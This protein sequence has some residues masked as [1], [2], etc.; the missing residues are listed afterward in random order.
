MTMYQAVIVDDEKFILDGL[1]KSIDWDGYDVEISLASTDPAEALEYIEAHPVQILITDVSMPGMSGLE[2]IRKARQIKPSI[3]AVVLSAYDNFEYTKQALRYGAEDYLLKPLDPDELS[4]CVSQIISHLKEREQLETLY[5]QSAMTFRSTFTEQW[6]T[7]ALGISTLTSKAKILGINLDAPDYMVCIFICPD[8]G[9]LMISM[10]FTLLMKHILGH[11]MAN[12]Y[13]ETPS[14]L[15]GVFSRTESE[16]H[17]IREMILSTQKDAEANGLKIFVSAGRLVSSFSQA[18]Q[19]FRDARE[20]SFLSGSRLPCFF[21][22]DLPEPY[23]SV[24]RLFPDA[25]PCTKAFRSPAVKQLFASSDPQLC[26]CDVLSAA[27]S[28]LS[29]KEENPIGRHPELAALLSSFPPE[30]P[31]ENYTFTER[32]L[33]ASESAGAVRQRTYPVVDAVIDSLK[34][35]SD[36]DISLKTIAAKLNVSP[37]YLGT[38][39][40]QQT[41]SLF[42]RLPR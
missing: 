13:F 18:T 30:H 14:R 31:E 35:F 25:V 42:Q 33:Q 4:D 19:S 1:R 7:G 39:F 17:S 5:G 10:F 28:R 3:N 16:T 36:K 9:E 41:G 40:H 24:R 11:Y 32:F 20:M 15:V 8:G 38:L 29:G 22:D 26:A 6:L 37:S 23:E 34:S 27:V 12:F 21:R 2:L